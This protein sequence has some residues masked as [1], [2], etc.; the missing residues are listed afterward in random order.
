MG[1]IKDYSEFLKLRLAS[2]VVLSSVI[3]Y[4]LATEDFSLYTAAALVIG[5]T[6]LTGAS[7]GFNEIIERD[8]DALMDRTKNRPLPASNM[9]LA[10]AWIVASVFGALGVGILWLIINPM[11]G[12][13]GLLAMFLY[14]VVYTPMK[15]QTPFAVFVGAFPGS[16]PPMLGCVA[17]TEGFGQITLLSLLMFS[18][19]FIWQFPHFWAIAWRVHDDYLKAGFKMLPSAGGRDKGTAFQI[20]VYTIGLIPVSLLPT[21]FGYTGPTSAVIALIAG[22][23]F[24]KQAVDLYRTL[25]LE[26]AKKLMFGSFVY[27]PLVQLAYLI[28]KI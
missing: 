3:C 14:A 6:L 27:L 5:G 1:K 13:L 19:Q 28:D 16:I 17:A 15:Q 11:S 23:I 25:S 26:D 21:F 4:A 24:T 10:E 18:V 12:I 22:I 7:N 8:L 20:V 2:L 9:K